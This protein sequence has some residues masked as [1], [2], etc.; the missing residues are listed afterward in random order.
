MNIDILKYLGS[1]AKLMTILPLNLLSG[2]AQGDYPI[3]TFAA[4]DEEKDDILER[5]NWLCKQVI[6]EPGQLI[7]D[8]SSM[9]GEEYQGEW[10]IY[11]CS[12]LAHALAN[13]SVLYPDKAAQCPDLIAKLIDI[14]N[15]PEMRKYDTMQ[16][17]EDA[18]QTLQSD[19]CGHMTYLS[20]LSWM[21]TNYK[22]AGGDGRF[23]SLLDTCCEALNRRMHLSQYDLNLLSFPRKPIWLPDMLVT[24]VA[25]KN[26]SRL[27]NGKY[28]DTVDAWLQNAKTKWIHKRT[29]LLVGTLPGASYRQKGIQIRGSHTALNCSYLTLID[30]EFALQQYELMKKVFGHET[31]LL[32]TTVVGLKEYQNKLPNFSA[33]PGDAGLIIKGISAG[34]MAFAPGAPTYFGDWEF[35]SQL[36]RTAEAASGTKKEEGMRH[37]NIADMFLVGEATM[38]AMRT[39]VKS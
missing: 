35:R 8:T 17:K 14:V 11:S 31:S 9:I 39:N 30:P 20:I 18:M 1:G 25:L 4:W 22:M 10:A 13:I 38:L 33:K 7:A 15:T 28:G 34:A 27:Y 32:G 16:W 3:R 5:A 19:K 12:M 36:L 37:Y 2:N 21:I 26:Y 24:I 29:G 23:D 6:K